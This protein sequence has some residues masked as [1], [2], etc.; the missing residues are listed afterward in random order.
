[1]P[2]L[3]SSKTR[4]DWGRSART[5]GGTQPPPCEQWANPTLNP[6]ISFASSA[7]RANVEAKHKIGAICA[8]STKQTRFL[9]LPTNVRRLA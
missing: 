8:M 6:R 7:V 4:L 9:D 3:P 2:G 1:M 5:T